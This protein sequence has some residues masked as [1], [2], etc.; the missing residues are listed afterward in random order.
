MF[1]HERV[2]SAT[3]LYLQVAYIVTA[4]MRKQSEQWVCKGLA[5]YSTCCM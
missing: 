5:A 2:P 1:V 4:A 3:M